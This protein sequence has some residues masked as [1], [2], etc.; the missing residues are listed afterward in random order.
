[1]RAPLPASRRPSFQFAGW[2]CQ[3]FAVWATMHAFHIYK[4]LAAAGLVL[5]LMNVAT[6]FPLWPGNVGLVQIAVATPLVNYGVAYARGVAFGIGLQAIEAS[7]GVGVGLVF[8]AREGLSYAMLK[9]I[10]EDAETRRSSPDAVER[11][12][13]SSPNVLALAAPA[14]LKGVLTPLDAAAALADGMR[15]AAGV[16]VVELPVADGGEGTAAVLHAALGGE[17]RSDVVAGPLGRP[18]EARW[19]VLPDGT[20]VVDSAAAV[21]LPLLA[22]DERRSARGDESRARRAAARRAPRARRRCSSASAARRRST[23]APACRAVVGDRPRRHAD[24][25]RLR[26][27]EPAARRARRG[28][29]VR[30]AE[31]RRPAAVEELERRLAAMTS[32]RRTGT[33]PARAP[34][35]VSARRSR[36][37]AAELVAGAELVLDHSASTTARG[38]AARRHRRGHRRRDDVR[39]QGAGRG[40]RPL[41]AARRALRALRRAASRDDIPAHA[42]SGDPRHAGE[43]LARSART[44]RAPAR[45]RASSSILPCTPSS[46]ARRA[47]RAPRRAPTAPSARRRRRRR[48]RAAR[49]SPRARAG[50]PRTSAHSTVAPNEPSATLHGDRV[51]VRDLAGRAHDVA[52]AMDDR[53]AALERR[54][55][56]SGAEPRM[57]VV[58]ARPLA[59]EREQRCAPQPLVR[60]VEPGR[61]GARRLR[62][63]AAVEAL[64]RARSRPRRS[65]ARSGTTRRA[66][67]SASRRGRRRRDRT[68]A[69]PARGRPPRRPAPRSPRPHARR[70][71]RRTAAGPRSCRRRAPA[72]SRRRRARTGR[73]LRWRST[74]APSGPCTYT[75]ATTTFAGGKRSTMCV[76]TSRFAAASFPVTSPTSRGKRGSARLRS[77]ANRPSPASVRLSRSSAARCA[78]RPKRSIVSAFSRSSP[79]CSYSSARPKT[80]TRSPSA[81]PSS[82]ASNCPRG[83]CTRHARAVLGVLEG[84]E[85]RRPALLA[86][87]LGDLALDPERRQPPEPATRRRG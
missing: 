78:P 28:A 56:L 63:G 51:A 5:V 52:A 37:S 8:L 41:P 79:R 39:G 12:R 68:A 22:A 69:C 27:P 48:A 21:G 65:S 3:L 73:R 54:D 60:R 24:P 2:M 57:R 58:E 55:G 64:P 66:A 33:C 47:G 23:A 16:D 38:A 46:F 82:S 25:R 74:P 29:R 32:S 84:E 80:C 7:V 17:W 49:R 53:V 42:L 20:A 9:Q 14:S 61:R 70:A 15:A 18:V 1:M 67:A 77:A 19:L 87:Q 13:A 36:R 4:P 50:P 76:S 26:R 34:A 11:P 43:D 86:P 10:E 59:L 44:P 40:P 35:A 30:P 81:R 72:R 45:W 85:H 6:I 62:A 71:R 83:I 75:S 31:G